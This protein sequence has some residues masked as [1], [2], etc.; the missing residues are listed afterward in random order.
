[1]SDI[2]KTNKATSI[3]VYVVE[4]MKHCKTIRSVKWDEE[5]VASTVGT[6]MALLVFLTFMSLIVNQYVPVWMKDAES[7]HMNEAFG[8]FGNLKNN[9]DSQILAC[10]VARQAQRSCMRITT[11]TPITLGV[12]GVPLFASPTSGDLRLDPRKGNVSVE[13]S[14]K[15]GNY[16][17][18]VLSNT[19]GNIE[20]SV[21]NRYFVQQRI[22]YENGAVLVYQADGELVGVA[23]HFT[24]ENRSEY[25]EIS[26]SQIMLHGQGGVAGVSTEGAETTL[27]NSETERYTNLTSDFNL[28]LLTD[29]ESAWFHY[30]N[31][32][33]FK[34]FNDPKILEMSGTPTNYIR[35][36]YFELSYNIKEGYARVRIYNGENL[37]IS[38]LY[39][40]VSEFDATIG[41]TIGRA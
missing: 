30:Y 12:D 41:E 39:L 3:L 7:A 8:Q 10:Q 28:T 31:D 4:I 1:M 33:L 21:F 16:T 29:Y 26:L 11:Y 22:I 25:I 5:G 37:P 14:Y 15:A 23:P 24:V 36:Q 35:T 19:S 18:N 17:V 38:I 40:I 6:I 20:L 27:I 2:N 9:I 32:T 13:F 34:A